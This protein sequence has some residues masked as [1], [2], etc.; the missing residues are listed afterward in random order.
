MKLQQLLNTQHSMLNK[1]PSTDQA[2]VAEDVVT[3]RT[4]E[5][6]ATTLAAVASF[7]IR[8]P[9]PTMVIALP[10][11]FVEELDTLLSNVTIA[12]ITTIKAILLRLLSVP[13]K[14][15]TRMERSGTLILVRQL[16]S[17][18]QPMVFSLLLLTLGTTQSWLQ[19]APTSP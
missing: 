1:L 13:F 6:E 9:R 10:V 19:M 15:L 4:V 7:N 11:R 3:L 12:L 18:L 17:P 8:A 16:T 5:E 2:I 14:C